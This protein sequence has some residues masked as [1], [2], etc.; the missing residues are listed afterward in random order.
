MRLLVLLGTRPEAIKM[1]P[2]ILELKKYSHLQV[3]VVST[4]QHAE[5]LKPILNFFGI[6]P[7]IDLHLMRPGQ[8][9]V[10]IT[11]QVMMGLNKHFP[12]ENV[13]GILVQGDTASC[14]AASVWAFLRKIPVFHVEAGLRTGDMHAPWPEEFNRRVTSVAA[15]L[16]FAPTLQAEANLVAE[17]ID[18]NSI[19]MVGNTVVDA[20][21]AVSKKINQNPQL[22]REMDEL[23]PFLD[24]KKKMILATVHRRENFGRGLHNVFEALKRLA[25]RDDVQVVLP[26]HMNP[27]VRAAAAE[28]LTDSNVHIID[29]QSYIPF[30]YLMKRSSLILT[31]SGGIQEEAPY[32]SKPVLVLRE[33]TER[34]ESLVDGACQLIGTN[35]DRIVKA[36][37][38]ILS[39]EEKISFSG[40][41][42]YG[43]GDSAQ[44]IV[45]IVNH[46]FTKM[47]LAN[48][49]EKV[50]AAPASI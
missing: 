10:E 50:S 22:Q 26:L 39:G 29:P 32:L 40:S 45:V 23:F 5:M 46:Y 36:A 48:H 27:N 18:E 24:A 11:T 3:E 49:S 16:H 31:D 28:I 7:D 14:M 1:A 8:S 44:K 35:T 30:V 15:D 42:P 12:E 47:F 4:G 21:L 25:Q 2:V 20:L 13:S 38:R 41:R 43:N 9:L 6:Q 34:P 33:S 19:F 17:G 37:G